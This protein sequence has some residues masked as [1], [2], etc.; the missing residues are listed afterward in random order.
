M[1]SGELQWSIMQN[2][3]RQTND[4]FI[5]IKTLTHICRM[6]LQLKFDNTA[7]ILQ[8]ISGTV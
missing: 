7:I 6:Q 2:T 1:V 8:I 5:L 4:T 3:K